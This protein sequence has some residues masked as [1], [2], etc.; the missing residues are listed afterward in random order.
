MECGSVTAALDS[1]YILSHKRCSC[2]YV[3][4]LCLQVQPQTIL[5]SAYLS[6]GEVWVHILDGSNHW[7]EFTFH[8]QWQ[9][10][11]WLEEGIYNLMCDPNHIHKVQTSS[12]VS[13][14]KRH[15]E[16]SAFHLANLKCKIFFMEGQYLVPRPPHPSES[17]IYYMYV[18]QEE[19]NKI[20]VPIFGCQ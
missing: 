15:I 1:I 7:P 18:T 20:Q 16:K 12:E 2:K 19:P 8:T 10:K 4:T 17:H 13:E 14:C 6:K 11:W 9:W 3:Q 5:V